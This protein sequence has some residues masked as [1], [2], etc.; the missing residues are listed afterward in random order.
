[1]VQFLLFLL[2]KG[3][4]KRPGINFY[5][6]KLDILNNLP[7]V[8]RKKLPEK[9]GKKIKSSY[10]TYIKGNMAYLVKGSKVMCFPLE[11]EK[12]SYI[13]IPKAGSTSILSQ[14]LKVKNPPSARFHLTPDQIDVICEQFLTPAFELQTDYTFFTVVRNPF[15]RIL[16]AFQDLFH[17]PERFILEDYLF[18]S[19]HKD[20]SFKEFV[21]AISKIP[22]HF[23]DPHFRP[24]Y[25]FVSEF[26]TGSNFHWFKLEEAEKELSGFL[27]K[28]GM[29]LPHLHKSSLSYQLQDFYDPSTIKMVR[30][31][32]KD[33]FKYFN[34]DDQL[35]F[36]VSS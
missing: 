20:M 14:M 26:T 29:V 27:N 12:L 32:Y 16:S 15:T 28:Y 11:S 1:M 8:L 13:R 22:D 34:Y 21:T 24:Q 35:I 18:G 5:E 23:K 4:L 3:Q 31:I 17:N 33:D 2:K 36:Q 10:W 25:Q 6:M 30:C 9:K 19:F 7:E